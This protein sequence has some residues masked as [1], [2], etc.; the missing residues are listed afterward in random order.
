MVA[1]ATPR[2]R[3]GQRLVCA[4]AVAADAP[5]PPSRQSEAVIGRAPMADSSHTLELLQETFH[6]QPFFWI[7]RPEISNMGMH[8]LTEYRLLI[9]SR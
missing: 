7:V 3:A 6:K 5:L 2:G 1:A 4:A 8:I 9:C